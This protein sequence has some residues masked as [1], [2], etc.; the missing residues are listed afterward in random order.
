MDDLIQNVDNESD[1]DYS[2]SLDSNT[3]NINYNNINYDEQYFQNNSLQSEY[4]D[5]R[6]KLFTKDIIKHRIIIDTHNISIQGDQL[7][8]SNYIYYFDRNNYE[9][10]SLG[11]LRTE[12]YNNTVGYDKY[13]NIIGFRFIKA[14]I[15]NRSYTINNTNNTFIIQLGDNLAVTG[16][17]GKFIKI[18][19]PTGFYTTDTMK[20]AFNTADYSWS[21]ESGGAAN[22]Y[23]ISVT[24]NSQKKHFTFTMAN[25][26][27]FKFKWSDTNTN[28]E[29]AKIL[30]GFLKDTETFQ[31]SITSDTTPDMSLHYFD[32]VI[33]EI[34]YIACKHNNEKQKIIERIPIN[35][36]V[37]E[38]VLYE[39]QNF[40]IED[41]KY[42]FPITLDK[43][44]IQLYQKN[45]KFFDNNNK[46]HSFEFEI[47]I[48]N[49]T[50]IIK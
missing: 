7:N 50:D 23:T 49:N 21:G 2:D 34:P 30:L 42:F 3:D 15:P 36:S 48:V 38:I 47:T 39:E 20:N 25:I 33:P 46:H 11:L 6:N 35:S 17:K 5:T 40:N 12:N 43:L 45:N 44:T 37:D 27:E 13:K 10:N 41:Q 24:F 4:L 8:T 18:A 1:S 32:I 22:T 31:N 9:Y 19:L 26:Y 14:I 28:Y 29:D 16:D